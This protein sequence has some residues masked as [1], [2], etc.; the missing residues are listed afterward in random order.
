VVNVGHGQG[1]GLAS[2]EDQLGAAADGA[3]DRSG[4]VTP[5]KS[6]GDLCR[7][8]LSSGPR[9]ILLVE[10]DRMIGAGAS[11]W[12]CEGRQPTARSMGV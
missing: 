10:D 5:T 1:Y 11:P 3:I 7:G 6:E 4:A 12:P 8:H 9:S 2:T